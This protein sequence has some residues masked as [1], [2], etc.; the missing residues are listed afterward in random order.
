MPDAITGILIRSR[1]NNNKEIQTQ[2]GE[3]HMAIKL[4]IRV[5]NLQAKECQR[6]LATNQRQKR[7]ED[8]VPLY[9]HIPPS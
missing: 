4:R 3:D 6:L 2:S 8:G 5:M 1:K 7:Q 9:C